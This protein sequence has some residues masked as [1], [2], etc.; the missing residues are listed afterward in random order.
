MLRRP[1]RVL[2]VGLID[3][4]HLVK[5]LD[6][7]QGLGWEQHL[8]PSVPGV[9]AHPEL[10]GVTVHPLAPASPSRRRRV[11]GAARE[12]LRRLP[13]VSRALRLPPRGPARTGRAGQLADLIQELAPDLV[14]SH[15][16]QQAGYLTLEA[17]AL[18]PSFPR[19][20]VSC[21]GNDLFLYGRLPEHRLRLEALLA[22]A[23]HFLC[24]SERDVALA[25]ELGLRGGLLPVIPIAG[26]YDIEA[27]QAVRAPGPPS[28][29]RDITLKGYQHWA[30][31][32]LVG[33]RALARIPELL[34]GRRLVVYSAHPD[35]ALAARLLAA[36]TGLELLLPGTL[37]LEDMLRLQGRA[38]VSVGLS[39]SDGVPQTF[40]E[41]LL[42]GAFPIQSSTSTA[43]EWVE[44]GVTGLLVPPE[45][46]T[47]VAAALRLAL[48]DDALVDAAA[49]R[50]L[51]TA[52][53]RLD[54]PTIRARLHGA[55]R[56]VEAAARA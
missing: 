48:T 26:G 8:A 32:A 37:S 27:S 22:A 38:R 52:R 35:V 34:V 33:L 36:D 56:E 51:E 20:A 30:G 17:R 19:W 6:L 40:L 47:A 31:R 54:R 44:D 24:D 46:P 29:R 39:I 4:I 42:L 16:L 2:H 14:F 12:A 50:N 55:L 49:V 25:R 18:L 23:D 45:E 21:W 11:R 28:A 3:S 7:L 5:L 9:P 41:A 43:S 15:E 1:L 10:R 13:S 53:R